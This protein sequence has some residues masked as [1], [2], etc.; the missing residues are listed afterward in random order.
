MATFGKYT[1]RFLANLF[2]NPGKGNT[3][4]SADN[5]RNVQKDLD[6]LMAASDASSLLLP[7]LNQKRALDASGNPSALNPFATL[8]D[9]PAVPADFITSISNTGNNVTLAVALGVLSANLASLNISQFTNDAGYLI[10]AINYAQKAYAAAGGTIVA[11]PIAGSYFQTTVSLNMNNQQSRVVAVWLERDVTITGV[12]WF[13]AAQGN[14]TSNN[15][16]GVALYTL[17]AG[18][19]TQVAASTND[20]NIWKG[21]ANTTQ[22][23]AFATPYVAT[24][25][26]YII[27]ALYCSSAQ[28]TQPT[29]AAFPAGAVATESLDFTN[30]VKFNG[31]IVQSSLPASQ[32]MTAVAATN[33]RAYLALY[34]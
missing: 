18:A 29:I 6:D 12:K 4:I 1:K 7:T 27:Q 8:G 24:R 11:E 14:Y 23:K 9:I 20:G 22:A 21:G 10:E 2:F 5:L 31:T 15:Y 17:A 25:G 34:T 19:M 26:L 33:N 32:N 30:S 16:N 28:V 3:L 13:Q